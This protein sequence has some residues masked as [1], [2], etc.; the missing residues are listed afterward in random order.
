MNIQVYNYYN[1]QI[2]GFDNK[3]FENLILNHLLS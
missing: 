3:K 1:I 2:K